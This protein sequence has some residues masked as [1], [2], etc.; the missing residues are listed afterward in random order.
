VSAYSSIRVRLQNFGQAVSRF[1]REP[2]G[3][4]AIISAFLAVVMVGLTGLAIDFGLGVMQRSKLDIAAQAAATS[5][6][7][8]ARNLLQL[9][10]SQNTQFDAPALAEGERVAYE[11]FDG[12]LG[13]A[14]RLNVTTKYVVMARVG[15]TVSA[16]FDFEATYV[17]YFAQMFN[18]N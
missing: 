6:A 5:G 3:A 4:V 13:V 14:S 9:N 11:V 16:Q 7:N 8:A 12:Q 2:R 15:N 10:M 17:P 18:I 1:A